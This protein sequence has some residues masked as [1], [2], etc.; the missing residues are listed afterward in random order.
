M[1]DQRY[2]DDSAELDTTFSLF[3]VML[4]SGRL[5]CSIH[6]CMCM[7]VCVCVCESWKY[8]GRLCRTGRKDFF[9]CVLRTCTCLC[10]QFVY[11]HA[12]VEHLFHAM[13]IRNTQRIFAI[14]ICTYT[15]TLYTYIYMCLHI[16]VIYTA[17]WTMNIAYAWS[18]VTIKCLYMYAYTHIFIHPSYMYTHTSIQTHTHTHTHTAEWTM[19]TTYVCEDPSS[20]VPFWW[21]YGANYVCM[22]ESCMC[23]WIMYVFMRVSVSCVCVGIQYVNIGMYVH[24]PTYNIM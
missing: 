3:A 6:L 7:C 16:H 9:V 10:R 14:F 24:T 23:E 13:Y 5:V 19:V 1:K 12:H 8:N 2:K 15:R 21:R 11:I 18:I 4:H 17:A 22:Y 20:V